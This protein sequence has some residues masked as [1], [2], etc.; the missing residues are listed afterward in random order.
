M[1][2]FQLDER[3]AADSH[4]V[5]A[6]DLCEVRLMNDSRYVWLLLV[7]QRAGLSEWHD[8]T[9]EEAAQLSAEVRQ[10]S[11]ALKRLSSADKINVAAIGNMVRQMHVH[12]VARREDDETWPGTVWNT[13]KAHPYDE[14]G[15]KV[16]RDKISREIAAGE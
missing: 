5:C 16:L 8:L 4:A 1:S 15:L 13:G 7:P 14:E 6:L 11:A 9:A 3:L 12:V 10:T 2:A